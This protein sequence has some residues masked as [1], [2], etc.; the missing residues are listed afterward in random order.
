M[1]VIFLDIDGVLNTAQTERIVMK[2]RQLTGK[3]RIPIDLERVQF[4]KE[5]VE[6]TDAV[7]VLSSAWK[8][9][10]KMSEGTYLPKN[11]K[12]KE[13]IDIFHQYG[14]SIYDITPVTNHGYRQDEILAWLQDKDVESFVIIDDDSFDLPLFLHKELIKTSTTKDDEM[15]KNM[16]DCT[17]LSQSQVMEA[18]KILN[19][20]RL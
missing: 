8:N 17:G 10:G 1:K 5:I 12:M 2:E 3:D 16:D 4:L 20:K 18:I 7:I 19:K 9:Y 13:L 6:T 15:V 11:E 14:L